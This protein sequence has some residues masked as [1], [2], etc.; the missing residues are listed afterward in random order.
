MSHHLDY[1]SASLLY[2]VNIF[3]I[4][5]WLSLK[6]EWIEFFDS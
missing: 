2:I 1:D 4:V 3:R 6:E 5:V